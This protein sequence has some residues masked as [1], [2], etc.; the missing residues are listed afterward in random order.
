MESK[1]GKKHWKREGSSGGN[2]FNEMEKYGQNCW[3][4]KETSGY[5][6]ETQTK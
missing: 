5:P 6:N 1:E 2:I 3:R 4:V